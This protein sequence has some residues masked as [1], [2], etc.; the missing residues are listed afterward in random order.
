MANTHGKKIGDFGGFK[1]VKILF[2][3]NKRDEYMRFLDLPFAAR[4][5][6]EIEYR[7]SPVGLSD[8][9][10]Q[11]PDLRMIILD[12]LWEQDGTGKGLTLGA[13]AMRELSEKAPKVPV[14]IYSILDDEETLYRLIP[15]MMRLGAYAWISKEEPKVMRDFKFESAFMAGCDPRIRPENLAILSKEQQRRSKVHVAVMFVDMS[16]FTAFTDQVGADDTVGIL[17]EFYNLV[18]K[19]VIENEGYIDKYIGDAVMAVFGASGEY[20]PDDLY[21]HVQRCIQAARR[22]QAESGSFRLNVE[23]TLMKASLQVPPPQ[24]KT[25]GLLRIGIESG[26]V[27]VVRFERG[28]ESELT[29]I[30]TPVNIAS[31][32]LNQAKPEQIWIGQNAHNTGVKAVDI[33]GHEEVQYKNLPGSFQMYRI[34]G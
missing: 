25:I 3:D 13:D 9:V 1:M 24:L 4:H 8:Y 21:I 17:K 2:V 23:K 33:G 26:L 28:T 18:G 10:A 6:D 16:G 30:G 31:R 14:V 27:E 5:K 22:V 15:E 32:I 19:S 29:F 20:K 11:N 7:E 34:N 12:I